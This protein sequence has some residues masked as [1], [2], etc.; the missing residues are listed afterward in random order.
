LLRVAIA[1]GAFGRIGVRESA[2]R[3]Y[4]RWIIRKDR[5]SGEHY[6]AHAPRGYAV[7]D[8][9]QRAVTQSVTQGIPTLEREER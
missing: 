1:A 2:P 7:L 3:G 6:R 5:R 8:A 4:S 9:R